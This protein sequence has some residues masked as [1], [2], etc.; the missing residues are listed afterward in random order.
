MMANQNL[1]INDEDLSESSSLV[2]LM[3]RHEAEDN[4]E[5]QILKHS[6]FYSE[7]QFINLLSTTAGLSILDLNICNAFTKFDEFES[8][9][10]RVNINYPISAIC[11]N[12]CWL[13]ESGSVSLLKLKD[14]NMFS[15]KGQCPGHSHCGLLIYVHEQFNCSTITLDCDST[16][17]EYMCVEVSHTKPN[18]KKYIICN[19]YRPPEK[20]IMELD[21]FIEEFSFFLSKIKNMNKPAY[22]NGDFNINLLE[23]NTNKHFNE[24]FENIIS[25]GFFPRITLPTRIQPPS[26]TLIDNILSND[27]LNQSCSGLLINDISD[28][29]M[30][31]TIQKNV[32]YK[33]PISKFIEINKHDALSLESFLKELK[34]LNIYE[35]LNKNDD[36]SPQDNYN[37]FSLLLK[38]AKNKHLPT[39]RVKFDRRK[40]K[41]SPWMTDGLLKSINTKNKL[42]KIL[43]QTD[44]E[45]ELLINRLK[46][47]YK[48]YRAKLRKSIREAKKRYFVRIFNIY[49]SDLKKTWSIINKNLKSSNCRPTHE[50][51]IDGITVT[52]PDSIANKFN[53]YF[54]NIGTSLAEQIHS[55]NC[56]TDY[57][58][59]P[60]NSRFEFKRVKEDDI[61]NIINKLKNKSSY[62]HDCISNKLLKLAKDHIIK[63][64]TLIINQSLRTGI[65]PGDL[66]IS[67]VKPLF[68][69]GNSHMLSNYR[70][71][72]L[73]P[74]ISKIFEY[75]LFHQLSDYMSN[76]NLLCQEQ[77]GFRSGFSTELAALR[78][79]DHIIK[80]MD[81]NNVP[82][83]IYID[84]SKAFDTL[85]HD[86]LI[87]KLRHNGV[88]GIEQTLFQNYLSDRYQYVEF[89]N[90]ISS[91]RLIT[92]GV[93]Q[94]S[95]LGPLLFLI[96]INDL[97]LV[98]DLFNMLM[99]AD[100]TTL[101]CNINQETSDVVINSELEKVTTWL[102]SNKLSLNIKKSKFMVFHTAQRHVNYP[103]IQI[104]NCNIERVTN[105]NFLGLILSADLKW[106]LHVDHICRKICKVIGITYRLRD[107]Y[108]PDVLLLL[109]N[110][111]IL[112][113]LNYCLI[114]WGSHVYEGHKVHLTQKRAI[115][116]IT[117]SKYIAHTEPICK[118]L[119]L[120]KIT[121]MFLLTVWKFYYK[122]LNNSL[123]AYFQCVLPTL[124][125][126]SNLYEIRRPKFYLPR[127]KHEFAKHSIQYCLTTMLN[128]NDFSL[129]I[130]AKVNTHS[131]LGFKVYI[132]TL[133]LNTY[134]DRCTLLDCTSCSRMVNV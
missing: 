83:S 81:S 89:N 95:I 87:S 17:W 68:K 40:H 20:Y 7:Q 48:V 104:N 128:S 91:K 12:E 98:S 72:S 45:A 47:E 123:P 110:T 84:L 130:A 133:I 31:F 50:F 13:K 54:V 121:D 126:S 70:P 97:P 122:L 120:L 30:I 78:L 129:N 4:E 44:L 5:T 28:H 60:T 49:R 105:F 9:V 92:T 118:S 25:K 64:L 73:L 35:Q 43:I 100:D 88:L 71:I 134:T 21:L 67:K 52:D 69:N 57:L 77:F 74:S 39:K 116:V 6:P 26:I 94:G 14:Y 36:F 99:Y 131:F 93:P 10:E 119:K 32:S 111:L 103:L 37:L 76:N 46:E 106:N 55:T 112:P 66:K 101:Y 59:I 1:F 41:I 80:E 23:I 29:K 90:A 53:E 63:P 75:V 62:G 3:D 11:L 18:S 109:Y 96:Y 82:I 107:I 24:Y 108:P 86:I 56:F 125:P 58:P 2:H 34:S 8:L 33:E 19:V 61:L 42:Y 113:H 38:F 124:P 79:T 127:V 65:F 85:D 114:I 16:G 27:I 51:E 115:R 132:K 15:Q 22:I 102:S 117:N